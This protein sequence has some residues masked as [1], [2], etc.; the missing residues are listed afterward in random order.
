MNVL[1]AG[2]WGKAHAIARALSRSGEVQLYSYMDKKNG[3]IAGL[4]SGYTLGDLEDT[5]AVE[6]YART[7]DAA[8]AVVSPY[9]AL[10]AG[11]ADVLRQQGIPTVG[12]SMLSSRLEG[13]KAFTR[14][15]MRDRGMSNVL[16][17]FDVFSDARKAEEHIVQLDHDF[18]VKPAGSPRGTASG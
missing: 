14:V 2:R 6:E 7:V 5:Q 15:L 3:A 10:S 12:A 8:L 4:S 18:A 1:L 16:P 17:D 13:D 11:V 9:M